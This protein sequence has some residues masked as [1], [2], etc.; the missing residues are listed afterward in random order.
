[1]HRQKIAQ[2][3]D[4]VAHRGGAQGGR[5][6]SGARRRGTRRLLQTQ[7]RQNHLV[8]SDPH[9]RATQRKVAKLVGGSGKAEPAV[10]NVVKGV[11]VRPAAARD[12]G[13]ERIEPNGRG[14]KKTGAGKKA[15]SD[16]KKAGKGGEASGKRGADD[17]KA[18]GGK[19]T[20]Q[21]DR[22]RNRH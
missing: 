18:K 7:G 11:N 3:R 20:R 15:G 5:P 16:A 17:T 10:G 13:A 2:R 19:A 1:M 4:Q 21:A 22:K 12:K 9:G 8:E 6:A 14:T